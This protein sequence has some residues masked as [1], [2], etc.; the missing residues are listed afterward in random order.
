[1]VFVPESHEEKIKEA[2]FESGAGRIGTYTR[3]SFASRGMGSFLSPPE[4]NPYVGKPGQMETVPEIR[5]E[6]IVA[7]EYISSAVNA[8]QGVHPYEAPAYDIYPL[9]PESRKTGLGRI[10]RLSEPLSLADFAEKIKTGMNLSHIRYGGS[11]NLRI[12]KVAICAGSGGSLLDRFLSSGADV[13]VS[14]DLGYHNARTVEDAG[15]GLVDIGHF[16]SEYPIVED[17]S[18]RLSQEL[19][20]ADLSVEVDAWKGESPAF[21]TI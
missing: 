1:M 16:E 21:Q 8:L 11:P 4:G 5:I 14:G 12:N 9:Q 6:T 15:K 3:C 17:L 10:G 2:L 18:Q 7:P 13:Y 20:K 19:E